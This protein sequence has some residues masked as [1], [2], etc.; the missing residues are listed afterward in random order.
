MDEPKAPKA[1][2]LVDQEWERVLDLMPVDLDSTA[3]LAPEFTESGQEEAGKGLKIPFCGGSSLPATPSGSPKK[4]V[5][6]GD[7]LC[8]SPAGS[9]HGCRAPTD[10]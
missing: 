4:G 3:N 9:G 2:P 8:T 6:G 7:P 5:G 10:K 1:H